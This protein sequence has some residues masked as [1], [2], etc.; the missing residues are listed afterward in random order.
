MEHVQETGFDGPNDVHFFTIGAGALVE[1]STGLNCHVKYLKI[2]YYNSISG[3]FLNQ[4]LPM[5]YILLYTLTLSGFEILND[6]TLIIQNC[7][8][9]II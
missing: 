6:A 4:V 5:I 3:K 9:F 1:F 8:I 7:H 2:L